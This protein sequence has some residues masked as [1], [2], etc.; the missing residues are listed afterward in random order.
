[1]VLLNERDEVSECTSANIFASFGHEVRTPP[2][3]SG[4]LPGIT[5]ELL[6]GDAAA[7][8]YKL[9]EQPLLL[10][11]LMAADSV[12]ITSTTRDLL[13]VMQI[14]DKLTGRAGHTR[15]ALARAFSEYVRNYVAAHKEVVA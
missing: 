1:M 12:F 6:L 13:P 7:S 5:R 14:E 10:P 11:D 9:I 15:Q 2:I 4:C 8:G 3:S